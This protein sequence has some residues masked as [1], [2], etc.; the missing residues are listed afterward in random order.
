MVKFRLLLEKTVLSLITVFLVLLVVMASWQVFARYVLNDPPQ[1]TDEAMRFTMIWLVYLGAAL[2]FGITDRHMSLGLVKDM[3]R[4]QSRMLF[5]AFSFAA[6]LVFCL[7][8][9]IKG[10]I[11]LVLIGEGQYS[12]SMNLPMNWVYVIIPFSGFLSILLKTQNFVEVIKDIRSGSD[13][14]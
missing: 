3:F 8:V 6:V 4:G 5:E 14:H 1:F 12:D 7:I 10:G 9:M 13:G 2:A 11:N